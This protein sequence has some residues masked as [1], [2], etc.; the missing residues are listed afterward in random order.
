MRRRWSRPEVG[1]WKVFRWV[2]TVA[3]LAIGLVFIVQGANRPADPTLESIGRVPLE[4]FG[5]I[6]FRIGQPGIRLTHEDWKCARLADTSD[7]HA[8]GLMGRRNLSGYDGMLFRFSSDTSTSFFMK[9]TPLPL[10][11]AWYDAEGRFVSSADM[12][13][14]L[15]APECPTYAA[16]GPYRFA[17]EV[18]RGD[19]LKLGARPG[20]RLEVGDRCP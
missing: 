6:A 9:D 20:S 10:S 2:L 14:C 4:G 3:V 5:E 1:G 13:P 11:I 12:D 8:Q 15:G 18:E 17:L 7:Q 16:K 19:L